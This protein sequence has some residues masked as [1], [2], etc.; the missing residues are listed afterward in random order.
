MNTT[1]TFQNTPV[2]H[3]ALPLQSVELLHALEHADGV[4]D[5]PGDL[6]IANISER[7]RSK[8]VNTQDTFSTDKM[9]RL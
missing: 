7:Q 4:L 2:F 8:G 9:K 5:G 3:R 6:I 1:E